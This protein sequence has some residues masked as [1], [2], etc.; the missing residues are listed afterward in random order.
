MAP[1]DT[2]LAWKVALV[3]AAFVLLFAA[4][5]LWPAVRRPS[6]AWPRVGRNGALW[7]VNV[8]L[9]L[10]FVVPLTQWAAGHALDWRPGWWSGAGGLAADLVVLD[11]L[12]YWWHR[13][14]H[15]V[16][17]LWR[18]HAVHHSSEAMDWLASSRIHLVDAVV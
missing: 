10:G 18:F 11:L 12:I 9:S 1:D 15:E 14:N 7:L 2:L 13:A 4:E 16:P 6:P 8:G 5:R 17:F 3:A